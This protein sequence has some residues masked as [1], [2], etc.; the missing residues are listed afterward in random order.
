MTREEAEAICGEEPRVAQGH[1]K[2]SRC[3]M[4]FQCHGEY[5]HDK[6]CKRGEAMRVLEANG[7]ER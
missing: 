5:D 6:G 2:C 4:C 3:T 7:D 1:L